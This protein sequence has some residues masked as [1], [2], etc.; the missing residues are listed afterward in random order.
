[1]PVTKTRIVVLQVVLIKTRALANDTYVLDIYSACNCTPLFLFFAALLA[2][3]GNGIAVDWFQS[4]HVRLRGKIATANFCLASVCFLNE[5][6]NT[7][8]LEFIQE[9]TY[10]RTWV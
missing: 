5:F 2:F 9:T 4:I 1:M 3:A 8:E 7:L 6:T 10:V